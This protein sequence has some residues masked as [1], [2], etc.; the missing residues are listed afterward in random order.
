MLAWIC[1]PCR[2]CG[3]DTG[4]WGGQNSFRR[5]RVGGRADSAGEGGDDR[6]RRDGARVLGA[7]ECSFVQ[8]LRPAE[9]GGPDGRRG[10]R[11]RLGRRGEVR[12]RGALGEGLANG[13]EH[14]HHRA[15]AGLRAADVHDRGDAR[16]E[17]RGEDLPAPRGVLG[18]AVGD[19]GE[20][21]GEQDA[22]GAAQLVQGAADRREGLP[23]ARGAHL[24]Q[25]RKDGFRAGLH[26]VAAVAVADLAVEL[27]ELGRRG[28]QRLASLPDPRLDRGVGRGA[29]LLGC[30]LLQGHGQ[31]LRGVRDDRGRPSSC[32]GRR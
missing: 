22:A 14:V 27:V 9:G 11:L 28:D 12:A 19:R 17:G 4:G 3:R 31:Q 5:H 30:L 32:G 25:E 23:G 2:S 29:G 24:R 8:I 15:H 26:G 13:V 18:D 20:H 21:D 7:L 16:G 6:S 1:L 10:V